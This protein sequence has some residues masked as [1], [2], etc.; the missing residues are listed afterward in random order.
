MQFETN[1]IEA[2][3]STRCGQLPSSRRDSQIDSISVPAPTK[4]CR[5][6]QKPQLNGP[7]LPFSRLA[8][9]RK[10]VAAEIASCE[11][12]AWHETADERSDWDNVFLALHIADE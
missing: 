8:T 4:F 7:M 9:I 3:C 11:I 5:Q 2:H 10:S 12:A 1:I 6:A